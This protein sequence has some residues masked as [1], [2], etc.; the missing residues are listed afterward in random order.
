[1]C[2]TETRIRP[3]QYST[4]DQAP[5]AAVQQLLPRAPQQQQPAAMSSLPIPD[6]GKRPRDELT[7]SLI[8]QAL[9]EEQALKRAKK[10]GGGAGAQHGAAGCIAARSLSLSLISSSSS[11]ARSNRAHASLRW[12]RQRAR[13]CQGPNAGGD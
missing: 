13:A 6:L 11:L 2:D 12:S 5:L 8:Q 3:K 1:M 10:G 9:A 4:P 7:E